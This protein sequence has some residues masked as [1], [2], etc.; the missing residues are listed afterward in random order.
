[1]AN[2]SRST[3]ASRESYW[4]EQ[5]RLCAVSGQS[6]VQYCRNAGVSVSSYHWWKSE[7]KRRDA[8][9]APSPVFAEVRAVLSPDSSPS[10]IEVSLGET[11]RVRVWPG[12]DAA[13]LTEVVRV[14]E[15]VSC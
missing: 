4:R 11:R 7:L 2:N 10:L 14:L 13:T 9:R 8:V 5:I 15:A 12:F 1:M 3:Q 6:V